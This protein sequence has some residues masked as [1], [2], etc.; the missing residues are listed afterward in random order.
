MLPHSNHPLDLIFIVLQ[1]PR[2]CN[3]QYPNSQ[4]PT[5]SLYSIPRHLNYRSRTS[6]YHYCF[7][8]I[9][10]PSASIR[11]SPPLQPPAYPIPSHRPLAKR[12]ILAF[13]KHFSRA[14][15]PRLGNSA[16]TVDIGPVRCVQEQNRGTLSTSMSA[17]RCCAGLA[18]GTLRVCLGA[19]LEQ[20]KHVGRV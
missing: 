17:P 10:S 11:L 16:C 6:Q 1:N 13:N 19:G 18:M 20:Y 15:R 7:P 9:R 2:R 4:N 14:I 5:P 8:Q 3:Y 12:R